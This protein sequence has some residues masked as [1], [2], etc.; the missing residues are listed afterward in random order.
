MLLPLPIGIFTCVWNLGV[1]E[2]ITLGFQEEA[3]FVDTPV[4]YLLADMN[5]G[6]RDG[7]WRDE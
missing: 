5:P 6:R 7:K 1:G 4:I 2:L 3:G